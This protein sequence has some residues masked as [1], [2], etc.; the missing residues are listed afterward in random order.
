MVWSAYMGLPLSLEG[1]GS[2]I[3]FRKAKIDRR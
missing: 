2:S 1:V 3:R